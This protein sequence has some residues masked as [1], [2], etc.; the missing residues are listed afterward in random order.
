M[1]RE[2][3]VGAEDRL[4]FR[5][6]GDANQTALAILKTAFEQLLT[7][8]GGQAAMLD[9]EVEIATEAGYKG[10]VDQAG[11]ILKVEGGLIVEPSPSGGLT[12]RRPDFPA[13]SIG[14]SSAHG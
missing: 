4:E 7:Q 1:G 5:D 10:T 6:T 14:G 2:I 8:T 3:N 12:V 9:S 11:S 13:D